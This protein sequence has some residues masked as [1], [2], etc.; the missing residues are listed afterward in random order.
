ME[1]ELMVAIGRVSGK[2]LCAM[3]LNMGHEIETME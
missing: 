3:V 1:W 2:E